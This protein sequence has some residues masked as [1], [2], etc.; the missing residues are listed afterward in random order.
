VNGK[1]AYAVGWIVVVVGL[2]FCVG[3]A[4]PVFIA[5][6]DLYINGE[7]IEPTPRGDELGYL[8]THLESEIR[9]ND[10]RYLSVSDRDE[11]TAEEKERFLDEKFEEITSTFHR[12]MIALA[13]DD[14]L[15]TFPIGDYNRVLASLDK[16]TSVASCRLNQDRMI[17]CDPVTIDGYQWSGD[18]VRDFI[19]K[20]EVT[21]RVAPDVLA[22]TPQGRSLLWSGVVVRGTVT[23][24]D[25][26][27]VARVEV[28]EVLRGD[29]DAD[30]IDVPV[31]S[32]DVLPAHTDVIVAAKWDWSLNA[33]LGA[34]QGMYRVEG[35]ECVP[36]AKGARVHLDDVLGVVRMGSL[37]YVADRCELAILGTVTNVET[38][39][40]IGQISGM[41]TTVSS[42]IEEVLKGTWIDATIDYGMFTS[43]TMRVRVPDPDWIRP[44]QRWCAFLEQTETGYYPFAGLH[45]LFLVRGDSLYSIISDRELPAGTLGDIRRLV[46]SD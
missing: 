28:G 16:I 43:G 36:V 30:W 19:N 26:E 31:R 10:H 3:L 45:G 35:D 39:Q 25:D 7:L 2:F 41:F 42:T 13:G 11:L 24:V 1:S 14:Y 27:A 33:Y 37:E 4:D 23:T 32:R 22:L 5:G 20:E 12:G 44:R 9:V 34:R 40:K 15:Q 18:V 21:W 17:V 8:F 6:H 46:G 29:V 38:A